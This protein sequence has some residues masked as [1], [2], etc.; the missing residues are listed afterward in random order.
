MTDSPCLPLPEPLRGAETG[1]F[2]HRTITGRLPDILRRT[3]LE[4]SPGQAH[5]PL[6]PEAL[7]RLEA[8]L[9]EIPATPVRPIH[10]PGAPDQEDWIRYC[11]PYI[12]R[13]WLQVP[14]F[15][16]ETY[17]Y[18]RILQATGYFQDGPGAEI[19]PYI[20]QKRQA[21][22]ATAPALV[23]LD[24]W[25]ATAEATV[26]EGHRDQR[27]DLARLIHLN[28]WGN[29]SDL[30][31]TAF[32]GGEARLG[33]Q[34][35][36]S[37]AS[38]LLVEDT[39]RVVE[40]LEGQKGQ[41]RV[42]LVPDN[43][44]L[45]LV[46]DLVLADYLLERG[47]AVRMTFHLKAHPTFVSDAVA[48]DVLDTAA[49]FRA[50]PHP[51]V[52]RLGERLETALSAGRL[53]LTSHFYWTSPLPAWEMP[54]SLQEELSGSTLLVSKG[55]ANYRRLLGDLHWPFTTPFNEIVCYLPAPL[56]ALRVLKS[57]LV[58]GLA[59]GEAEAA[60]ALDPDWLLSGQWGVI[61]F[62]Q[63]SWSNIT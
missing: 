19:D 49:F 22:E 53:V 55:D 54:T 61:Q 47:L 57:E 12:G 60:A 39:P 28:L 59:P 37:Q 18:R 56:V 51:Q 11:E 62:S 13:D 50:S 3:I 29:Q 26:G 46:F 44:G 63:S 15:F 5:Q 1:S 7:A 27:R 42:D 43:A 21:L 20:P 14:W 4:N 48:R 36:G 38:Q 31:M 6:P 35:V 2:A 41:A 58:A 45:E 52:N 8:L 33:Y 40:Y 16:I 9:A 34:D 24:N 17:F 30:S 23:F 32:W 10:D 25:L